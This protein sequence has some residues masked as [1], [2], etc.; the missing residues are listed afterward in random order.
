MLKNA[1]TTALCLACQ[2][3]VAP[4]FACAVLTP[5]YDIQLFHGRHTYHPLSASIAANSLWDIASLT[6]VIG[7]LYCYQGLAETGVINLETRLGDLLNC[8]RFPDKSALLLTDLLAHRAGFSGA[9]DYFKTKTS[10]EA[11]EDAVLRTFLKGPAG[12]VRTYDDASYILLGQALEQ[13][14]EKDLASIFK[15]HVFTSLGMK[16]TQFNPVVEDRK[17]AVPTEWVQ[18][19]STVAQGIVHDENTRILGGVAGHAGLFSTLPDLRLFCQAYMDHSSSKHALD[20][21][22]HHYKDSTGTYTLGWDVF[23]PRTMPVS[24]SEGWLSHTGFTGTMLSVSP[25][26][27]AAVI[28]LSN[29]VYPQRTKNNEINALRREVLDLVIDSL[30]STYPSPHV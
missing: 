29:R 2:N 13:L 4:G 5:E 7:T 20:F 19:L 10:K 6:K 11:I 1:L 27:R 24:A 9:I 17:M 3:R 25:T 14:F 18:S 22:T 15:E 16:D 23:N 28:L 26:C 12:G 30:T 8:D 21:R